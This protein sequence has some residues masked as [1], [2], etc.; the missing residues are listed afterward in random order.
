MGQ[1]PGISFRRF[2]WHDEAMRIVLVG[3]AHPHRGGIA[4]YTASLFKSLQSAGHSVSL[5][6]FSRQYPGVFFPGRTQHD[7]SGIP[8]QVDCEPLLDSIAPRSWKR[9]ADRI[10]ELEPDAVLFQWW[11]PFFSLAYRSIIRRLKRRRN[12]PALFLCHNILSHPEAVIPGRKSFEYLLTRLAFRSADGFL[13]HADQMIPAVK[14][15]NPRGLI[16]KIYHPLY[17]FYGKW[18]TSPN[19]RPEPDSAEPTL[20]FFGTIRRYKGLKTL[21]EGLAVLRKS[22]RFKA[23]IA[24][25]FYVDPAPYYRLAERLGLNGYLDWNDHYIPN[26]EVPALFRAADL[27]VLPYREATQSGVVSVAYQFE[28]PVVATEVGGLAE[29]VRQGETGYLVPPADPD[30]LAARIRQFFSENRRDEFRRNIVSFRERLTWGQVVSSIEELVHE[31]NNPE[32]NHG[33]NR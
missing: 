26:E 22:M 21:L 30:A 4:H 9:V 16:R 27:V 29:V 28:V 25:E 7:E 6:S 19:V 5:I 11:Q 17:D 31:L 33:K 32:D 12:T 10:C 24:G 2:L 1:V 8:L 13:V 20:L 23:V 15:L 18:D 14:R 3:P